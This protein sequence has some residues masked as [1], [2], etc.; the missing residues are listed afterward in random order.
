MMSVRQFLEEGKK[1]RTTKK[2]IVEG[3][4][5]R[6]KRKT[7]TKKREIRCKLE[8]AMFFQRFT[9]KSLCF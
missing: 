4:T 5:K 8:V 9:I 7:M 3:T 1:G 2:E 6:E